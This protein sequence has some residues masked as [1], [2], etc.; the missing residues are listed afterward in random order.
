VEPRAGLEGLRKISPP[1]HRDSILGPSILLRVKLMELK[2]TCI[3][4]CAAGT[5]DAL[6]CRSVATEV[7]IRA[8]GTECGICVG[9]IGTGAR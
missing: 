5:A 3:A 6:N 7:R 4:R 9:R 1:P 2:L 8:K